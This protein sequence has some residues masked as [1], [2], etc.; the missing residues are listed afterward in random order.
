LVRVYHYLLHL[1]G[2]WEV[3]SQSIWEHAPRVP[4]V[5]LLWILAVLSLFCHHRHG[6]LTHPHAHLFR[7]SHWASLKLIQP[8]SNSWQGVMTATT[9]GHLS[10][11]THSFSHWAGPRLLNSNGTAQL[12]RSSYLCILEDWEGW[13][14]T[15][16]M[17]VLVT[18]L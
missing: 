13:R 9:M 5:S 6:S 18:K 8:W 14:Q 10:H 12:L 11:I 4:A 1:E 15:M 16:A 7:A 2:F 3:L 17:L